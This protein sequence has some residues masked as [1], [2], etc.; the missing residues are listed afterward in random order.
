[1]YAHLDAELEKL[2]NDIRHTGARYEL[3]EHK[4]STIGS[5]P[6]TRTCEPSSFYIIILNINEWQNSWL[7][8]LAGRRRLKNVLKN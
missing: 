5:S 8:R 4:M 1:M 2:E 3:A 7:R 6:R